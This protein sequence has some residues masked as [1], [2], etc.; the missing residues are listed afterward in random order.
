MDWCKIIELSKT[1][2]TES[3]LSEIQRLKYGMNNGRTYFNWDHL[4]QFYS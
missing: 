2:L 4:N 3:S 1:T